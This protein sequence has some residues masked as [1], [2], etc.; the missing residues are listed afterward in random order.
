MISIK[1]ENFNRA[2]I[3]L[4]FSIITISTLSFLSF[5]TPYGF[6]LPEL[7]GSSMVLFFGYPESPFAQT[8]NVFLDTFSHLQL[9]Y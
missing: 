4:I 7:F 8:M 2:I 6:F 3:A 1:K 5:E 9:E